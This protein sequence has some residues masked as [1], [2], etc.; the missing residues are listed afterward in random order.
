MAEFNHHRFLVDKW[1][2]PERLRR[3]LREYGHEMQLPTIV[4]WFRRDSIPSSV[5]PL[6]LTLLEIENGAPV[7]TAEYL[8]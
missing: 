5:L 4:A 2:D 8:E 3:W 6:L 1:G 7:S